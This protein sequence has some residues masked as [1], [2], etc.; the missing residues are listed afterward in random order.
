MF[1]YSQIND[2]DICSYIINKLSN[3][4]NLTEYKF[5]SSRLLNFDSYLNKTYI[6][7]NPEYTE[8]ANKYLEKEY[9]YKRIIF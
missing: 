3:V 6:S 1:D 8:I 2:D 9:N 5:E 4:Q 7:S